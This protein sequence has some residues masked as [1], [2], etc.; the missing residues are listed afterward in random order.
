MRRRASRSF[1]QRLRKALAAK[2][3]VDRHDQDH[4]QLVHHM[5]QMVQQ[6]GRVEHQASLATTVADQC[7]RAID[8]L[9]AF[10]VKVIWRR[11]WR[12]SEPGCPP[13]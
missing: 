11:P 4:V 13:A 10:R 9:G 1:V 5:V 6:G 12:T 8:M 3:G 7:Q 2:A